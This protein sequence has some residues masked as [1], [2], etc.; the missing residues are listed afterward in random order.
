M[1]VRVGCS[2]WA[3]DDWRGGF[4]ARDAKPGEYLEAYARVFSYVELDGTF[5]RMPARADAQRWAAVTPQG[6]LLSPKM[7]RTVTHDAKLRGTEEGVDRFL[8]A[9]APLRHAGKL[10]PVLLQMPP[11]FKHDTDAGALA[12][13]LDAWPTSVPLAV[14]LRHKSWWRDD[15]YDL[16]R[17]QGAI[18]C[19]SV[20]EYGRTPYVATSPTLYAR[21]IGD[22]AL[23]ANG[24]RWDRV[25][26]DMRPEI[27]RLREALAEEMGVATSAFVIAN[28]HFMG[29]APASCQLVAEALG[30]PPFDLSAAARGRAQR[31]LADFG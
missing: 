16:L 17:A 13:F 10:G 21:L 25:Q 7:T 30:Q 15:T 22:R 9:L 24:G 12:R 19:W 11:G 4:Y 26:R 3:Y 6:F 18:L 1:D 23:D 8:E 27:Q 29:F 31:G 20:N 14:E 2:G 5:Y 28:N